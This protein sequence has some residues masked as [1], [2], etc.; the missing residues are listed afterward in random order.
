MRKHI[1]NKHQD[2]EEV[3]EENVIAQSLEVIK[4]KEIL[5]QKVEASHHS[6]HEIATYVTEILCKLIVFRCLAIEFNFDEK[7]A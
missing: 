3:L 4:Y 6:T 5:P 7:I 2:Q 1:Q